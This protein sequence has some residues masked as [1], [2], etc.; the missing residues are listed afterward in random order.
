MMGEVSRERETNIL[1]GAT[2]P[3]ASASA[4]K[5]IAVS[6]F[7][8]DLAIP[9]HC[10]PG[11]PYTVEEK[12]VA[13]AHEKKGLGRRA[14]ADDAPANKAAAKPANKAEAKPANKSRSKRK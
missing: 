11:M 14:K 9:A 2:A 4:I 7:N 3:I 12:A 13:D 10:T 5:M 6:S 1:T 8:S